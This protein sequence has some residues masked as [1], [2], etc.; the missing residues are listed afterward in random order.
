[1]FGLEVVWGARGYG[2]PLINPKIP[3]FIISRPQREVRRNFLSIIYVYKW[4]QKYDWNFAIIVDYLQF[5]YVWTYLGYNIKS[6]VSTVN[7]NTFYNTFKPLTTDVRLTDNYYYNKIIII[8]QKKK[9]CYYLSSCS[10][11]I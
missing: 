4:F 7:M 6:F 11:T 1:M 10:C 5:I 9:Q 8:G 2:V 3:S